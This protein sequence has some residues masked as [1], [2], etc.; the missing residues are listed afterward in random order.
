ML[1]LILTQTFFINASFH[2]GLSPEQAE[3]HLKEIH[4]RIDKN[5]D[6]INDLSLELKVHYLRYRKFL[7]TTSVL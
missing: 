5:P 7:N 2:M 3:H 4:E 6:A 1:K